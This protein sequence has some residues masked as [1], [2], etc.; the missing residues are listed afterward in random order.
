[1]GTAGVAEKQGF[2]VFFGYYHQVHAHSYYTPYLW[3]NSTRVP[4]PGNEG[5]KRQQYTHNEIARETLNFI[6]ANKDQPF[7][8]YAPWTPPHAKYEFPK[9]DPAWK[10]YED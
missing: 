7:F 6:R 10:M 8:C 3:R 1:M 2:D 5:K 9:D 4:L